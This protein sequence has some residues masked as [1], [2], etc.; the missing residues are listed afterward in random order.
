M[1]I[2]TVQLC[3]FILIVLLFKHTRWIFWS[4]FHYSRYVLNGV[5]V[6]LCRINDWYLNFNWN[7]QIVTKKDVI[8]SVVDVQQLQIRRLHQT[9]LPINSISSLHCCY[10][11]RF[12]GTPKIP[13]NRWYSTET[14]AQHTKATT[15]DEAIQPKRTLKER[16]IAYFHT[17]KSV[18][19]QFVCVGTCLRFSHC[20]KMCLNF[21]FI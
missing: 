20:S 14:P 3:C 2:N 7:T 8:K 12:S 17:K 1:F 6:S 5:C 18:C 9:K 21:S 13:S 15:T 10:S 16:I 4:G 11:I 19:I